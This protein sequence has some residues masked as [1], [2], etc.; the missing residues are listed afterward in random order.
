[1]KNKTINNRNITKRNSRG[2]VQHGYFKNDGY[3][4]DGGNNKK[5]TLTDNCILFE[6]TKLYQIK[7][8]KTFGDVN[9]GDLGGYVEDESNLSQENLCWIYDYAKVSGN[10]YATCQS[11]IDY[12]LN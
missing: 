8:L 10:A 5:Y 6:G 7:A 3:F 4:E 11:E 9:K 1:M 12:D 2:Y